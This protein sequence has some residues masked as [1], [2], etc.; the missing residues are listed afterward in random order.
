MSAICVCVS[1]LRF[2]A[3]V[4]LINAQPTSGCWNM[5][6]YESSAPYGRTLGSMLRLIVGL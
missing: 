1:V 6:L 3:G 2:V 5:G 4:A